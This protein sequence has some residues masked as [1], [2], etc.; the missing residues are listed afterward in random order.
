VP[1]VDVLLVDG[2]ELGMEDPDNA[3]KV[4]LALSLTVL[5]VF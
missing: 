5:V 3:A 1:G 2:L 4:A